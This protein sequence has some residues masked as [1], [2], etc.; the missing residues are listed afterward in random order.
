[1]AST[2]SSSDSVAYRNVILTLSKWL[3]EFNPKA[4]RMIVDALGFGIKRVEKSKGASDV[5]NC[6]NTA[7]AAVDL[8]M[9][10]KPPLRT[11]TFRVEAMG[12][13][14]VLVDQVTLDED[15]RG[16]DLKKKVRKALA[17]KATW[18]PAP[19]FRARWA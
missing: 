14:V 17:W 2:N 18:L 10:S 3:V 5:N 15:F 4:K 16:S 12:S 1:M 6:D 11:F 7:A 19:I 9:F 13:G 8:A